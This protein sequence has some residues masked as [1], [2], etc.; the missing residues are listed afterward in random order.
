[1]GIFDASQRPEAE[2]RKERLVDYSNK[3]REGFEQRVKALFDICWTYKPNAEAEK[4]M[5]PED[6]DS[7][8]TMSMAKDQALLDLYGSDAVALFQWHSKAQEILRLD[9]AYV[10]L[11]PPYY[12]EAKQ[13]GTVVLHK[14]SDV[15]I[16]PDGTITVNQ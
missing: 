11:V 7:L 4:D 1:M 12:P 10:A 5:T 8:I 14:W 3:V 16:N 15:T 6:L 13:D 9:P 2:V